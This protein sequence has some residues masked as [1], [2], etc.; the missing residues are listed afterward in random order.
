MFNDHFI[1]LFGN[2]IDAW[3]VL[4]GVDWA[5]VS[6]GPEGG[7][8]E[9]EVLAFELHQSSSGGLV[10]ITASGEVVDNS[11]FPTEL[12]QQLLAMINASN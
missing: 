1:D 9:D 3:L 5:P 12:L 4:H 2:E 8:L 7:S 10:V 11:G 6:H